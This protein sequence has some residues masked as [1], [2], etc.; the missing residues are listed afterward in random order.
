MRRMNRAHTFVAL[1]I[2]VSLLSLASECRGGEQAAPTS[3]AA[4]PRKTAKVGVILGLTGKYSQYGKRMKVGYDLALEALK[5]KNW[6]YTID[7]LV[8]DSKFDPAT[9]VRAYQQLRNARGVTLYAGITGSKNAVAV[10]AASTGDHVLILDPLSSAPSLTEKCG[11][12]YFRIMPSDALAGKYD[13]EWARERGLKKLAIVHVL[14]DWGDSYSEQI[15][16][17]LK[18][19]GI[20]PVLVEGVNPGER[21]YSA[22]VAKIQEADPDGLFL[23]LYGSDAA[24][25]MQQ[26]RTKNRKVQVFGSDNLST[27][28]FLA[29]GPEVVEGT[30]IVLPAPVQGPAYESLKRAYDARYGKNPPEGVEFDVNVTKSYDAL[31][32]MAQAIETVGPHPSEVRKYLVQLKDYPSVSGPISFDEKGD[33]ESV[34]YE[35]FEFRDGKRVPLSR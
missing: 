11:P 25:F 20:T 21:D 4:Q 22:V 23:L 18:T 24:G 14:D 5:E 34:Q 2:S 32:L 29:A 31:M 3:A 7:L 26:L 12:N 10:C 33:L 16:R 1:A 27:D 15:S 28:E 17:F 35:R 9:A 8:E 19:K 30:L 13:V 6:Q